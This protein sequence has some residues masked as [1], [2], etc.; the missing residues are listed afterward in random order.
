MLLL[1]D[2]EKQPLP[3]RLS[4]V[5]RVIRWSIV[6]VCVGFVGVVIYSF[7]QK[8]RNDQII[9]NALPHAKPP[10][11]VAGSVPSPSA[12][13]TPGGK[14]SVNP[15]SG[16]QRLKGEEAAVYAAATAVNEIARSRFYNADQLQ[17]AINRWVV[18][19]PSSLR[20]QLVNFNADLGSR[21]VS[22][23]GYTSLADAREHA[24]YGVAIEMFRVRHYDG[25]D[26]DIELY[27]HTHYVTRKFIP[28]DRVRFSTYDPRAIRIVVMHKEG[29]R[30]LY[31][32]AKDPPMGVHDGGQP[33]P[34]SGLTASAD[35]A[36]FIPYLKKGYK[37]YVG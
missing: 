36:R 10:A 26:A 35:E 23:W 14:A 29:R 2:R 32:G 33:P 12:R 27:Q 1:Q 7:V 37:T 4:K 5:Q 21:L 8:D 31:A 6:A 17:T 25:K 15:G 9:K 30:W 24:Q 3:P 19:K 11:E 18:S 13:S 34:E 22:D 16:S 28:P 20:S